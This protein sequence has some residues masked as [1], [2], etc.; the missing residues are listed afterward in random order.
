MERGCGLLAGAGSAGV[1]KLNWSLTGDADEP[2]TQIK[3]EANK[4]ASGLS[5]TAAEMH[6]ITKNLDANMSGT[7][8][9]AIAD[10]DYI[11]LTI[12]NLTDDT[13]INIRH[14]NLN[15]VKV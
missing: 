1:Y 10:G 13:D 11:W 7:G 12:A 8:L 5:N 9:V 4:G 6:I 3:V 15:L 2:T 14:M